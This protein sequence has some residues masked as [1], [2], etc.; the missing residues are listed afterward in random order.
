MLAKYGANFGSVF[1]RRPAETRNGGERRGALRQAT[2]FR[3][4]L[5]TVGDFQGLC[6]IRNISE[7]GFMGSVH[8]RLPVGPEVTVQTRFDHH[9][10]GRIVWAEQAR[11]G[12]SF[13]DPID[14]EE[15]LRLM[16]KR[17]ADGMIHRAPRISL[18]CK[19]TLLIDDKPMRVDILDISQGGAKIANSDLKPGDVVKLVIDGLDSRRANVQWSRDGRAGLTFFRAIRFEELAEWAIAAHLASVAG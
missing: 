3:P 8:T 1:F 5:I 17:V 6:L 15:T 13:H 14:V 10:K 18:A 11:I 4:A 16:S 9:L 12:V 7:T 2:I 19:G